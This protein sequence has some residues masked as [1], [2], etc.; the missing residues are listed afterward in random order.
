MDEVAVTG[1]VVPRDVFGSDVVVTS[2][3]AAEL[4]TENEKQQKPFAWH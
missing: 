4:R 2:D 3:G 1:S